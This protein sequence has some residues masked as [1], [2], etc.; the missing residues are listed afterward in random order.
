MMSA[1]AGTNPRMVFLD[2]L[3][4]PRPCP[5][6]SRVSK[7]LD[8]MLAYGAGPAKLSATPSWALMDAARRWDLAV[9]ETAL[10]ARIDEEG[11]S[12][13]FCALKLGVWGEQ[14]ASPVT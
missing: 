1:L 6:R 14:P 7:A 5:R 10:Q 2:C 4:I 3:A 9:I 12:S 13:V 11:C 8:Y